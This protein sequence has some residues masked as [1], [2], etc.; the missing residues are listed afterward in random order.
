MFNPMTNMT[1]DE[2]MEENNPYMANNASMM[3]N[4]YA[5]GGMVENEEMSPLIALMGQEEANQKETKPKADNNPYPSLAEMIRQQ[6]E[7]QDT[8]LAHINPV[9][10]EMLRVMNGGKINPVT[11]LPQFGLF[12][13]PKKWFK[14]VAGPAAGVVLGNMLLPGIGGVIG[15]AM[16]GGIGSMVRG[17]NDMGQ[18]MLRGGA[19]GAMVPTAASLVG[20]GANALG[21]KGLGATL[22]NY[23]A[24][25]AI[26]PSIGLGSLGSSISGVSAGDGGSYIANE[27]PVSD[28]VKRE[29]EEW[30]KQQANQSLGDKFMSGL[31]DFVSSP[32]NLLT[33]AVVGGSFMNRPKPPKEKSPEEQAAEMKRLQMG[34]L[35]TPQEQAAKEAADLAAEQSRR[36][37]ARNKFLPEERFNIEPLHVKTNSPED[38]KRTG[39]WLEYYNNPQFSGSPIMMKEG[40]AVRND[41]ITEAIKRQRAIINSIKNSNNG[42][43]DEREI[44]RQFAQLSSELNLT[45]EEKNLVEREAE[46]VFGSVP[47][48]DGPG[49]FYSQKHGE[50]TKMKKGGE[51]KPKISYEIEQFSYPS[52]LGFYVSGETKGQD[53][54]IPAMLSDGEYVIPADT[55]AHLGDGNNNAGAKKL[56]EMIKKIRGSKGMKNALPPKAK[57]LTTYLGV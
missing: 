26:L 17:R 35:L 23:G 16:G 21:A 40:G 39:R 37:I 22:S 33:A 31:G 8:V 38:Y 6:G 1:N 52:G 25:N 29:A 20:S 14:S 42:K 30:V 19:M 12:S 13:N 54:K 53:D 47:F 49:Y 4:Y 46:K 45:N 3:P 43:L 56:D 2:D 10:A 5:E 7:G 28:V 36:R 32:S 51:V 9:E 48:T 57:S 55:V 50:K 18:A 27:V 24:Q 15:G 11:G 44:L 41:V 34:L